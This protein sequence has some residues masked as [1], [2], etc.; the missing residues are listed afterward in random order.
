MVGDRL[1]ILIE[2]VEKQDRS[3]AVGLGDR[4]DHIAGIRLVQGHE[5]QFD[6]AQLP[7]PAT[8]VPGLCR[9]RSRAENRGTRVGTMQRKSS[10]P[11]GLTLWQSGWIVA[12]IAPGVVGAI[13]FA[14][15]SRTVFGDPTTGGSPARASTG[16]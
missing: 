6:A 11:E 14:A 12:G 4:G 13:S 8:P 2:R 7:P 16:P 9:M 3:L 10:R 1:L 5:L 15:Q